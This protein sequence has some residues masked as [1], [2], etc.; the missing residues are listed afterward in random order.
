MNADLELYRVFCEVV[1]HK[2]ISKT[3]ESMYV[4]Q[5]AVTQSIQKLE[6]ILGGNVFNRN[7]NGVEL[8]EEGRNL[9]E[10]IKDSIETMSNAENIF[11]KYINL[12]KGK[13]RIGGGNSLVN[14][15]IINPM[16]EFINKYPNVDI[17]INSGITDGLIQK[18]AN[19]ELDL[20]VLNLPFKLNKYS[21]VE[22]FPLKKSQYC[23]FCSKSYAKE[24]NIKNLENIEECKFVFP[25]T[26]SS[27]SKIL[28][29]YLKNNNIEINPNYEVS[30]TSIMKNLV[31]SDVGIGFAKIEALNDIIGDIKIIK[32]I[33]TNDAEE[34]IATLK[35]NMCNKATLE[36]VKE[37]KKYYNQN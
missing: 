21:N 37:I 8:T 22:V 7:K 32:K 17:L 9:Y 3:A 26:Y 34:G 28:N 18:L 14:S 30:S 23:L 5:S 27:K 15:L 31:M 36:L 12:E 19:G 13:I 2:N 16:I 29:E 4:S 24:H 35:K 20:V 6:T 10:Y 1:K 33:S 11:S 25:K